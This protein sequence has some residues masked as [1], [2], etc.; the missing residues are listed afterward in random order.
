MIRY[1]NLD[2]AISAVREKGPK[3]AFF[4]GIQKHSM[5]RTDKN[6]CKTPTGEEKIPQQRRHLLQDAFLNGG[7]ENFDGVWVLRLRSVISLFIRQL[8]GKKQAFVVL[9]IGFWSHADIY[10]LV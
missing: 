8:T 3:R 7:A 2:P 1:H 9:S 5:T 6:G 10:A 4:V